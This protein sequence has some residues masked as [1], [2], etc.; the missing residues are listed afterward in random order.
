MRRIETALWLLGLLCLAVYGVARMQSARAQ[1]SAIAVLEAQWQQ[2]ALSEP[3]RSLWSAARIAA[4]E[5]SQAGADA[6][7]PRALLSIPSV[8][9]RVAVFEGTSDR[10]L[11]LGA[12]RVPGTAPFGAVGNLALAGHRDGFFRGLKDIAIDDEVNLR[13]GDANVVYRVTEAFVVDPDAVHVLEPTEDAT[14]TLITC[15]PFYFV[16][17]APQRFIVRAVAVAT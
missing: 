3:D 4:Y 15:Y 7:S 2:E 11:N 9:V 13:H 14:L 1:L 8:G 12:G 17:H 6:L 10:T 5:Q 16:G